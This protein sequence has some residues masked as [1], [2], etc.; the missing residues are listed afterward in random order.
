MKLF[1][2]KEKTREVI[3]FNTTKQSNEKT[4]ES[5]G[6]SS[7]RQCCVRVESQAGPVTLRT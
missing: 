5:A 6:Q 3:V 2:K 4:K 1:F 7:E